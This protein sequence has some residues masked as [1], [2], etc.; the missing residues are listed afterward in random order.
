MVR[1]FSMQTLLT[2]MT[3]TN[4]KN[5]SVLTFSLTWNT[6]Q[7][8]IWYWKDEKNVKNVFYLVYLI[9]EE[10][11]IW[12]D[13]KLSIAHGWRR[14]GF[15]SGRGRFQPVPRPGLPVAVAWPVQSIPTSYRENRLEKCHSV[16]YS[17]NLKRLLK[18]PFETKRFQLRFD[19]LDIHYNLFPVFL[20]KCVKKINRS[21]QF[22][23]IIINYNS[24][25]FES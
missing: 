22:K 8:W 15:V 11:G 7:F 5:S 16:W 17:V 10:L 3:W 23:W 9:I 20:K 21:Y 13:W 24:F 6:H 18:L 12:G 25:C 14:A 1:S 4:I 19:I 2:D